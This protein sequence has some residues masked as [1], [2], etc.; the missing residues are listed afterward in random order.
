MTKRVFVAAL[1]AAVLLFL[2]CIQA[3]GTYPLASTSASVQKAL[4]YFDSVQLPDGDIGYNYMVSGWVVMGLAAAGM[5][6]HTVRV[7]AGFSSVIDYLAIHDAQLRAGNTPATDWERVILAL[8]A[9]G[10]DPRAFAGTDHVAHLLSYWDGTQFGSPGALNDDFF[11]VLALRS[12]GFARDSPYV[13]GAVDYILSHQNPDGGWSYAVGSPS[14]SDDTAAA[15]LALASVGLQGAPAT[16]ASMSYFDAIQNLDGGFPQHVIE[17]AASP[18]SNTASDAW[19]IQALVAVG[20]DPT[21]SAWTTAS[22]ATPVSSLLGLQQPDGSFAWNGNCVCG[23]AWMT[24]YALPALVG[25]PM[26]VQGA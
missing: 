18:T 10:E 14:D 3:A 26:P 20:Q 15:V 21:S 2:P 1:L 19:V 11:A 8:T 24:A 9:A 17:G 23:P 6:P 12:A 22:G 16:A 5:D 7:G 13:A 25:V 4:A